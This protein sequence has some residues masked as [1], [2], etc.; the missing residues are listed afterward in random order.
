MM[1]TTLQED[2]AETKFKESQKWKNCEVSEEIPNEGQRIIS[3][4]CVCTV[5]P[6]DNGTV[7]KARLVARG[8]E[9]ES[10]VLR[11]D[12][13]KCSKESLH[14]IFTIISSNHWEVNSLDIQSAILQGK[15][16]TR[17]VY[18]MPPKEA[19]TEELLGI[20]ICK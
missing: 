3:C 4:R 8:F 18:L 6:I 2:V 19:G 17:D 11:K 20:A 13:P 9:E 16:I 12:S 5:K 14:S 15:S 1:E 10:Y 7:I